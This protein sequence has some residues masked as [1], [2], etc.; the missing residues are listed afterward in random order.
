LKL[1]R[2]TCDSM[3]LSVACTKQVKS[4]FSS[5]LKGYE[6][7]EDCFL[8]AERQKVNVP[9]FRHYKYQAE[10]LLGIDLLLSQIL[11]H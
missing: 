3:Q 7:I 1:K 2:V 4:E 5:D 10:N 9:L 6:E 11:S 8:S